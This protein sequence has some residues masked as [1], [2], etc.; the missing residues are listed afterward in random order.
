MASAS[1]VTFCD[2]PAAKAQALMSA[3]CP[4]KRSFFID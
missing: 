1:F 2:G 3:M 4:Q